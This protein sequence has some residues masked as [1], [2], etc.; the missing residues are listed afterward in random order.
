MGL[1]GHWNIEAP[2]DDLISAAL[3]RYKSIGVELRISE[4]D[5]SIYTANSDPERV[6]TSSIAMQQAL[7]YGRFFRL[8]RMYKD[9]IS[10]VTTWGMADN[11]T[12]LDNFPVVGRKNYPLLF[13]MDIVPK[14]AYFT[15][16]QF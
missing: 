12:W 5:V 7:A 2:S 1:Q 10:G 16:I 15:V 14:Q 11:N 8:F 3:D 4:L 9:D 6:F 13:D